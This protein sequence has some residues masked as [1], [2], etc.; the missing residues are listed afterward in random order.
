MA[1]KKMPSDLSKSKYP[2]HYLTKP[3][4]S[5]KRRLGFCISVPT[6]QFIAKLYENSNKTHKAL[7]KNNVHVEQ[8]I[9]PNEDHRFL[10]HQNWVNAF[11]ASTVFFEKYLHGKQ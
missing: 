9:F 10:L 5:T 11:K 4:P 2:L 7:R 3:S 8:L 1:L 6:N